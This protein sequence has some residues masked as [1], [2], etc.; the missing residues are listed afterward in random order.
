MYYKDDDGNFH[1]GGYFHVFDK[2]ARHWGDNNWSWHPSYRSD[3]YINKYKNDFRITPLPDY[4]MTFKRNEKGQRVLFFNRG[5]DYFHED[6]V[7]K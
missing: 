2:K 4:I 7:N 5:F 3:S 6:D 1:V